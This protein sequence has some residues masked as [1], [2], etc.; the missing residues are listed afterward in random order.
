MRRAGCRQRRPSV[1]TA[2]QAK[3]FS[4]A[5]GVSPPPQWPRTCLQS[6]LAMLSVKFATYLM[7]TQSM[8]TQSVRIC[9]KVRL[10]IFNAFFDTYLILYLKP[11]NTSF[12]TNLLLCLILS[13]IHI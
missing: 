3:A 9:V 5:K 2:T 4:R 7:E 12:H 10:T 8:E 1:P 13:L 6:I 11:L